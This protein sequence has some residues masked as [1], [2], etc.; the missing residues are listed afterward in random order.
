M[1][2]VLLRGL[3][4]AVACRLCLKR[5][6]CGVALISHTEPLHRNVDALLLRGCG[7]SLVS[8]AAFTWRGF[9]LAHRA[10]AQKC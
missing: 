1:L 4:E 2:D 5:L 8:E 10:T 9:D 7:M 3:D 6:L